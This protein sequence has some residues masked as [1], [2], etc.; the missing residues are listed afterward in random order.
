MRKPQI[1]FLVIVI[2]CTL[3]ACKQAKTNSDINFDLSPIETEASNQPSGS[4]G[5][6]DSTNDSAG[7]NE[8]F[9]EEL[10]G[11]DKLRVDYNL[12]TCRNLSGNVSVILFYMDDFESG[13]TADEITKFTNN[14]VKPGLAFLEREAKLYGVELNL[15]IKQS[16]SSIFYDDEVIISTKE[17]G[18]ATIDVLSQAAH[19][20]HYSSDE[21]MIADFRSQY[22]TE[23]VCFTIFNKNGTAYAINPH[24]GQTIQIEEH[25]IVFAYD[26]NSNHHDPIGSQSSIVA[27]ELLHL[28]GAEDYYA[29]TG[30]KTLSKKYYP[31]DIMLSAN[32]YI[33]TN[34][35]GNATAFYIGWTDIVP[36]VLYND[37]W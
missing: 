19:G 34:N 14:E 21:E 30:R 8:E 24:R 26:L 1:I 35:I 11:I 2:V 9:V 36:D 33:I 31:A 10:V 3:S 13:W 32:Y 17:T 6:N 16:Y 22:G 18:L 7:N 28:F 4:I 29:T 27:H 25:C 37:N 23:I 12:G 20:L 5:S 15:S